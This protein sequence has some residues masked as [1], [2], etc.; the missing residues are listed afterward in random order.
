M[1]FFRKGINNFGINS[2]NFYV[3]IY[4]T[5]K[6]T[7]PNDNVSDLLTKEKAD[8]LAA[9][10][11]TE[12]RNILLNAL[13]KYIPVD[14][15]A[16]YEAQLAGLRW[17]SKFGRPTKL[18]TFSDVDPIGEYCRLP[19][20]WVLRKSVENDP[21]PNNR[22]LLQV[23]FVNSIPF[24]AFGFLDN[25]IMIVAG[26]YIEMIL[27]KKFPISTMAAAALGN[28]V[29]DV[30]G[31]GST[32]WVE[33]IAEKIGFKAP[34]LNE[35]QLKMRKTRMAVNMGRVVGITIGCLL[36]MLTIPAVEYFCNR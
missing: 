20:D 35:V 10:L 27:S 15:K 9:K 3:S 1:H 23:A 5:N 12:E 17:R 21:R 34:K 25:A 2:R 33:N 30:I 24:I 26:D 29:S 32:N 28:T 8:T 6:H 16:T 7:A 13:H 19:E 31:I 18:P 22:D 36:G 4:S 11:S 14:D